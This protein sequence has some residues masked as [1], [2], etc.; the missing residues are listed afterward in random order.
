MARVGA[1]SG[2]SIA[3]SADQTAQLSLRQGQIRGADH[4]NGTAVFLR[5]AEHRI[6]HRLPGLLG[7]EGACRIFSS[8]CSRQNLSPH[9]PA[10]YGQKTG[11]PKIGLYQNS[12]GILFFSDSHHAG[13]GTDSA[14]EAVAE[15]SC[16]GSHTALLKFL[17]RLSDCGKYVF[18]LHCPER[19]PVNAAVVALSHHRIHRGCL[20]AVRL[21]P[22]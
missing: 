8:V 12:D 1:C 18:L 11:C 14:L 3:H 2:K 21:A 16:P 22:L 6:F 17:S 13:S 5:T 20:S 10:V 4:H 19:N 9:R 7:R 15:R